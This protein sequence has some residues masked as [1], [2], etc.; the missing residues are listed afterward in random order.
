METKRQ[1]AE[2]GCAK[3]FVDRTLKNKKIEKVPWISFTW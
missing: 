3:T 1:A 2:N